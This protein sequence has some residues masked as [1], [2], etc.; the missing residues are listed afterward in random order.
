MHHKPVQLNL[1]PETH[2]MPDTVTY[3][4]NFNVAMKRQE[5]ETG[6]FLELPNQYP[7]VCR[8]TEI[9]STH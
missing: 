1:T 7:F 3:I 2:E 9:I 6:S 8:I 4:Y 5:I